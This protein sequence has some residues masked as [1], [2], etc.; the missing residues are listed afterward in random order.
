MRHLFEIFKHRINTPTSTAAFIVVAAISVGAVFYLGQAHIPPRS[1][2]SETKSMIDSVVV[3]RVD[4]AFDTIGDA[5]RAKRARDAVSAKSLDESMVIKPDRNASANKAASNPMPTEPIGDGIM[6]KPAS[7]VAATRPAGGSIATADDIMT[8]PVGNASPGKTVSDAMLAKSVNESVVI[9]PDGDAVANKAASDRV[10]TE[11]IRDGLATEPI[12]DASATKPG[13]SIATEPIVAM[14]VRPFSD[15]IGAKPAGDSIA[16]KP[17]GDAIA[18]TPDSDAVATKKATALATEWQD[19]QYCLA[20]S[21]AEHKIYLSGPI[22]M[23]GILGKADSPFHEMLKKAGISHDEVQCP[24]APNK[25]T[26]L[27]RQ[28]FAIRLNEDIGNTIVLLNWEPG[29]D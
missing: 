27:F 17:V 15:T 18:T 11:P 3:K 26:L 21:H 8:K 25:R 28:R 6:A 9:K 23:I 24:K 29:I 10:P 2:N 12:K 5:S 14:P 13:S 22:P 7:D 16:I 1:D 19:W 4:D 20:P